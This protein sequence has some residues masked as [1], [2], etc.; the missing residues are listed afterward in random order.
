ML[1]PNMVI[2]DQLT[3]KLELFEV[4]IERGTMDLGGIHFKSSQ[5]TSKLGGAGLTAF[6]LVP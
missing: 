2:W 6:P 5:I 3:A 1:C 4:E